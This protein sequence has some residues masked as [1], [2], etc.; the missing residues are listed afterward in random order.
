MGIHP[1]AVLPGFIAI[2]GI[3]IGKTGVQ[4]HQVRTAPGRGGKPGEMVDAGDR[5]AEVL[6]G[7]AVDPFLRFQHGTEQ[8]L[9]AENLMAATEGADA[10][11]DLIERP[12]AQGHGIGIIDDPCIRRVIPDRFGNGDEH[13]YGAHGAHEAAGADRIAH[14]LEDPNPLRQVDIAFHFPE[15]GGQDGNDDKIRTGQGL[16]QASADLIGPAGNRVRMGADPAADDLVALRGFPVNIVQADNAA[17]VRI[18]R[19][20]RHESPGPSPGT[21]ADICDGKFLCVMHT[22]ILR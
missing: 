2:R 17:Q 13:G 7:D 8:F 11:E 9:G 1:V 18:C 4:G 15:G 20:V 5:G 16:L 10:R 22:L 21:A 3:F 19:Q 6:P 14:G 12:Y